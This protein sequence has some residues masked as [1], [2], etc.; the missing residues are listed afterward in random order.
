M[1]DIL[2]IK[3]KKCNEGVITLSKFGRVNRTIA[4]TIRRR[5]RRVVHPAIRAKTTENNSILCCIV[6]Y[7]LSRKQTIGYR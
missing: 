3:K 5:Y 4:H 2:R 1:F 6:M 7:R